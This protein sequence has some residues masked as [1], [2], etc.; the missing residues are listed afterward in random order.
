VKKDAKEP[1]A[2]K[3]QRKMQE[4]VQKV[5]DD[6]QCEERKR[7]EKVSA[8]CL[9]EL[10]Q[11]ELTVAAREK[12][13]S[14]RLSLSA[15]SA[16]RQH[17]EKKNTKKRLVELGE[18]NAT[19]TAAADIE[20]G[21]NNEKEISARVSEFV[22]N[23]TLRLVAAARHHE[24]KRSAGERIAELEKIA[25]KEPSKMEEAMQKVLDDSQCEELQRLE[26]ASAEG[27]VELKQS[28]L[29]AAREKVR[30]RLSKLMSKVALSAVSAMRQRKVTDEPVAET[31][32]VKIRK[33]ITFSG[34]RRFRIDNR[35]RFASPGTTLS[36]SSFGIEGVKDAVHWDPKRTRGTF[37]RRNTKRCW[38]TGSHSSSGSS[39]PTGRFGSR[40]T[41]W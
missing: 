22:S 24:E 29:T 10:K 5:L 18:Q 20:K 3:G 40:C 21:L 4:A 30:E 28:E 9:V 31:K 13:I 8:E 37:L 1:T 6:S 35:D 15:V 7:M 17:E 16:A 14:Q 39:T 26:N 23:I 27:L 41:R 38:R 36:G 33:P 25:E 12:V 34:R 11:S 32:S 2:E 19:E